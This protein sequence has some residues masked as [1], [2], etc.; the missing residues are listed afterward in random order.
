MGKSE[1]GFRWI[2]YRQ[3]GVDSGFKRIT[4]C[5]S[6]TSN[7]RPAF[8]A[9]FALRGLGGAVSMSERKTRIHPTLTV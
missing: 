8:D 7:L 4:C 5:E 2:S 9:N 6:E 3:G 1:N